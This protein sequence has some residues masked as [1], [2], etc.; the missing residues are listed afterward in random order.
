MSIQP[1]VQVGEYKFRIN[2]Y[3][4]RTIERK[5]NRRGGQWKTYRICATEESA[6][7]SLFKLQHETE[8]DGDE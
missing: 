2:L 1:A 4:K 5:V 7:R 3:N 6:I 8:S